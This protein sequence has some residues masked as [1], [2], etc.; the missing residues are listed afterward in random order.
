VRS[1]TTRPTLYS[2][3]RSS[4]DST[5]AKPTARTPPT[6]FVTKIFATFITMEVEKDQ[7]EKIK[8]WLWF[9][10]IKALDGK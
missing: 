1:N 7:G 5:T 6:K 10:W 4:L 8:A 9:G 3:V 2:G